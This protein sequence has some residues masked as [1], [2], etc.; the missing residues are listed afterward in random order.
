MKHIE[1]ALKE[2][3]REAWPGTDTNIDVLK[4][5][6]ETGYTYIHDD[7]TPWCAAFLNWVL[8][9]CNIPTPNKLNA[10][11]FLDIG[12][13]ITTPE[14]G[15]IVIFWRIRSDSLLGHCGIFLRES[16]KL[17]W[18]LGGNQDSSVCIKAFPKSQ[19]LGYRRL[20][21]N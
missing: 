16:T 2:Y 3:G 14:L 4:F 5:F 15:D 13:P 18:V 1:V 17:V 21:F 10:R 12:T 19:L 20:T 8:K 11:S 6:L 7:E 9:Q